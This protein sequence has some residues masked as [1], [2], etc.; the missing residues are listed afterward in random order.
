[1]PLHIGQEPIKITFIQTLP[2]SEFQVA[3]ELAKACGDSKKFAILKA[4]GGW[5][6][7][8][9]YPSD[10]G[11]D[12]TKYGLIPG[13]LKS[14]TLLCLPY[15]WTES[16]GQPL[17]IIDELNLASFA[18]FS[19]IKFNYAGVSK[20]KEADENFFSVLNTKFPDNSHTLC[21][22]SDGLNWS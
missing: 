20:V 18:G 15:R 6:I 13:I 12:L 19:L 22:R 16:E 14:N 8:L 1:M 10:F 4:F 17:D 5:D 2:G 3:Q 9:L 21:L 11:F 7:I